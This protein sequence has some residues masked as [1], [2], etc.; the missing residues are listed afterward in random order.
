MRC[1]SYRYWL[2]CMG[3]VCLWLGAYQATAASLADTEGLA[4]G[5]TVRL[6]SAYG[7]TFNVFIAGPKQ[8]TTAV[9][10][11]PGRNGVNQHII[12]WSQRIAGLGYRALAPDLMDGRPRLNDTMAQEVWQSIDPVWINANLEAALHY[13]Q[14]SSSRVVIMSWAPAEVY[15]LQ[16]STQFSGFVKGMV[17]LGDQLQLPENIGIPVLLIRGHVPGYGAV[18]DSIWD[19]VKQF[20]SD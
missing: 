2:Q 7:T 17:V 19:S 10:L 3:L 14:Q 9:L 16:Q 18:D 20:L 8:A 5:T 6:T 4:I 1:R 11:V 12:D 15:A 13:L